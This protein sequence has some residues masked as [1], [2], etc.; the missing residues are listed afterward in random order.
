MANQQVRVLHKKEVNK[1]NT[2]FTTPRQSCTKKKKKRD[3]LAMS[4]PAQ[5]SLIHLVY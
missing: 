5:S 2:T 4:A 1:C 3:R